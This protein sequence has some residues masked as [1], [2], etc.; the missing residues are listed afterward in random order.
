M[1]HKNS[2]A[3]KILKQ[4]KKQDTLTTKEL[5]SRIAED[6]GVESID[7]VFKHKVRTGLYDLKR[8]GKIELIAYTTYRLVKPVRL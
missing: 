4:L 3:T 6:D 2:M 8:R 5:C 7:S 1:M